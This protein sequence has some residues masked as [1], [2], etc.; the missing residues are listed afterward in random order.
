MYY[1]D[2]LLH[3]TS[4]LIMMCYVNYTS[5][6]NEGKIFP[7]Q[8]FKVSVHFYILIELG[9]Y[10][11]KISKEINIAHISFDTLFSYQIHHSGLYFLHLYLII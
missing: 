9:H 2:K 3:C 8:R 1:T 11:L 6:L 10:K 5:I 4:K 7:K